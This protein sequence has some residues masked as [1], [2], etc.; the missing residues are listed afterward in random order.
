[1]YKMQVTLNRAEIDL[2]INKSNF[3]YRLEQFGSVLIFAQW[4]YLPTWS[5]N[6]FIRSAEG[7]SPFLLWLDLI[8][9][10]FKVTSGRQ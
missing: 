4:F 7:F 5:L 3:R 6:I 1:M 8:T 9:F 10:L 2:F